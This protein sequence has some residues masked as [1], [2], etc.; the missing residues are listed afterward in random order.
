MP[1]WQCKTGTMGW[2]LHPWGGHEQCIASLSRSTL[3][4]WQP[5]LSAAPPSPHHASPHPFVCIY[6]IKAGA[7]GFAT[8]LYLVL[9][10]R[11]IHKVICINAVLGEVKVTHVCKEGEH[12]EVAS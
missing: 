10:I 9:Q 6:T 1:C 2:L 4:T 8:G 12:R 3:Y 5:A 11:V 7:V